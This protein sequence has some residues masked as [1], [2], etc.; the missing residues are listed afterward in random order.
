MCTPHLAAL[1]C[2]LLPCSDHHQPRSSRHFL[3][4][5]APLCNILECKNVLP[6]PWPCQHF[7]RPAPDPGPGRFTLRPASLFPLSLLTPDAHAVS[8]A[9]GMQA[10]SRSNLSSSFLL[11]FLGAC[12][13]EARTLQAQ[14][15]GGERT[16]G[17][18]CL[19]QGGHLRVCVCY[20]SD[21]RC[22]RGCVAVTEAGVPACAS[23]CLC[24]RVCLHT[25]GMLT[26]QYRS[27]CVQAR[28]CN[29]MSNVLGR[30]SHAWMATRPSAR[31]PSACVEAG[32]RLLAGFPLPQVDL[33]WGDGS[34]WE[35]DP[36][37][38]QTY[39]ERYEQFLSGTFGSSGPKERR[40][41]G[42][43]GSGGGGGAQPSPFF[44]AQGSSA[45]KRGGGGGVNGAGT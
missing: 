20:G 38:R 13:T 18:A 26:T 35:A 31:R 5:L 45:R 39:I 6:P 10:A 17:A 19:D 22:A 40:G 16:P 12:V 36:L 1:M 41:S 23:A 42:S 21:G 43:G 29:G 27:R 30:P 8:P 3:Q 34:L 2:P 7:P 32:A 33:S 11:L 9:H 28:Q 15:V 25:P 37:T 44:A 24:G 14:A 4:N